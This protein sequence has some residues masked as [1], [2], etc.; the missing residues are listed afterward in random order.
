MRWFLRPTCP[1]RSL[2]VLTAASALFATACDS[3][4]SGKAGRL[5][6]EFQGP[7]DVFNFNRPIAVGARLDVRVYEPG[8][9]LD[10]E[11]KA[12]ITDATSLDEGVLKVDAFRDNRLTLHAIAPGRAEIATDARLRNG[13]LVSD[14]FDMRAETAAKLE[15]SP[16]CAGTTPLYLLDHDIRIGF[17]LKTAANEQ[18]VG[19][20]YHPVTAEPASALLL[21][22]AKS[23]QY[24]MAFR[25]G[26]EPGQATLGS[27]IDATRQVLR[28]ARPAD[29][30]GLALDTAL[31]PAIAVDGSNAVRVYPTIAGDPVCQSQL[32]R[33]VKSLTPEICQARTFEDGAAELGLVQ[34]RT[35]VAIEGIAPGTCRFEVTLAQAQQGQGLTESFS[36]EIT[37][38]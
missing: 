30:D 21:D 8:Q 20:G 32:A 11:R 6:Y 16:D 17:A 22:T 7:G 25:T 18:L 38:P 13:T 27:D 3:R 26:S 28:L 34:E 35:F 5:S 15:L 36:V 24:H 4:M 2:L 1:T 23:D 9:G 33:E 14:A 31:V 37:A 12:T 29:I 19:Y 10:E